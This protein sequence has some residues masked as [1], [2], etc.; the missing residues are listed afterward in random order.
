MYA[1][2]LAEVIYGDN[3]NFASLYFLSLHPYVSCFTL[4]YQ[5]NVPIYLLKS[6]NELRSEGREVSS[7]LRKKKVKASYLSSINCEKSKYI[8]EL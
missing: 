5:E 4:L 1:K 2:M 3:N 7:K 8:H 6:T